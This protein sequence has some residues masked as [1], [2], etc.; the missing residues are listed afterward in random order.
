MVLEEP[1]TEISG[2]VKPHL[3]YSPVVRV[4]ASDVVDVN[5]EFYGIVNPL[6]FHDLAHV[7]LVP[8]ISKK[9][10]VALECRCEPVR[11][12]CKLVDNGKQS[13]HSGNEADG[14]VSHRPDEVKHV[15]HRGEAEENA[16]ER[17]RQREPPVVLCAVLRQEQVV[18]YTE[19]EIV[20]PDPSFFG[21]GGIFIGSLESGT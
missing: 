13:E 7:I 20:P 14:T 2:L 21:G 19:F 11:L 12:R 4:G 9:R 17:A 1:D 5:I 3:A 16:E 15:R 6:Q 18:P 8:D 10:L